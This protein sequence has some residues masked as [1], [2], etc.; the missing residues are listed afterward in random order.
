MALGKFPEAIYDFTWALKLQNDLKD[1]K[2]DQ[3]TALLSKYHRFAGNCY[4]EMSQYQEAN[5]HYTQA[6]KD[7]TGTSYFNL[8]LV[9]SKLNKLEKANSAFKTAIEKF[10]QEKQQNLQ[11]YFCRYNLGINYRKLGQLD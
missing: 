4:F 8:G 11:I 2:S 1:L 6:Q 10:K 9:R 3:M 5:E 7:E